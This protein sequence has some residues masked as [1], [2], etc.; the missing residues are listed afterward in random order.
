[1]KRVQMARLGY[2]S[3]LLA[4]PQRLAGTAPASR[5]FR[6]VVRVL[7]LR[8]IAQAVALTLWPTTT[9]RRIGTAADALHAATDA[10]C[11]L[12][13]RRRRHAAAIDGAV[14]LAF[15]IAAIAPGGPR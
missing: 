2:G 6:T 4:N 11:A 5:G 12:V 8:H 9:A 1:M 10:G 7:G 15:V 3:W 14:A 13:D